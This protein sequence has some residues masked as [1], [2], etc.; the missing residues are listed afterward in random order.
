MSSRFRLS[1]ALI[2]MG[3]TAAVAF[4]AGCSSQSE[5]A[6]EELPTELSERVEARLD[7]LDAITE[8][9]QNSDSGDSTSSRSDDERARFG[10]CLSRA[11]LVMVA[12]AA[13]AAFGTVAARAT[14]GIAVLWPANA[15]ILAAAIS[16]DS[17]CAAPLVLAGTVGIFIASVGA[18]DGVVLSTLLAL[19]NTIE[20]D[21]RQ[22]LGEKDL[23]PKVEPDERG[24]LM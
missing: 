3:C 15:I 17:R 2:G 20:I 10:A 14:E 23:P 5:S 4:L 8:H 24:V 16:T 11:L 22:M 6:P 9:R 7:A 19:C 21:L 13:A 18:G 1:R 12:G